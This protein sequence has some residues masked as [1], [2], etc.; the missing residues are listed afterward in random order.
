M[1]RGRWRDNSVDCTNCTGLVRSR[2]NSFQFGI[3]R[4]ALRF[5]CPKCNRKQA[6]LEVT[7]P[8][9]VLRCLCGFWRVVETQLET[10]TIR[11]VD[12]G[13]NVRLPK[14]DSKLYRTLATLYAVEPASTAY[15]TEMLDL[16][17]KHHV[18]PQEFTVS[19]VASQLTVLKYRGLVEVT[20]NKK[21]VVGGS[22]WQMTTAAKQ[23]FEQGV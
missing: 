6:W 13:A 22:T 14:R 18:V 20:S 17:S 1:Y 23:M 19:D 11:H 15:V 5:D 3:R 8:D 2:A 4:L 12:S 21:G 9:V 16:S 7:H 10:I